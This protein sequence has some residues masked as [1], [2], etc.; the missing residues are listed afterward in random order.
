MRIGERVLHELVASTRFGDIRWLETVDSTNRWG[1]DA[2]LGGAPDGLVVVA[3]HQAAG[4]GRLGRTWDSPPGA[5][6]LVSLVLRPE[7]LGADRLHLLTATVGLAA[8]DACTAVGG[9]T[10]EL[11]WPND[12]LVGGR[13]LAGILAEVVAAPERVSGEFSEELAAPLR[14]AV[15]VGLGLNLTAAPPGAIS[16]ADAGGRHVDRDGLLLGLLQAVDRRYGHWAEVA[17]EYRSRCATVGRRVRID[18]LDGSAR[19]GR[20]TGVDD[21]GRLV[22]VFDGDAGEVAVSAGDVVHL[23]PAHGSGW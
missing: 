10:P 17:A 6:L 5:G 9:F 13:K 12:L 11:K 18:A 14:P 2:A 1:R 20:A 22:V 16:A 4:R 8:L 19:T 3:D 23:R 7:H 21:G 15:V